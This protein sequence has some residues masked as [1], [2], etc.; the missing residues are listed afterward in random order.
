[1]GV[2]ELVELVRAAGLEIVAL[3]IDETDST[4]PHAVLRRTDESR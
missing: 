3:N 2:R 4:W 1:M